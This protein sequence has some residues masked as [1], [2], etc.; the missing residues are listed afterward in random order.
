METVGKA[1]AFDELK[2]TEIELEGTIALIPARKD[3]FGT[4]AGVQMTTV[5]RESPARAC[6]CGRCG[7]RGRR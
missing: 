4:T 3:G 1:N 2:V 6:G 5:P 7:R